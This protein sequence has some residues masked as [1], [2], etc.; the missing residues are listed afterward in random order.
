[1]SYLFPKSV[2]ELNKVL[3]LMKCCDLD[4]LLMNYDQIKM[5]ET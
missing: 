3:L 5:V 1:M 2:E 4:V